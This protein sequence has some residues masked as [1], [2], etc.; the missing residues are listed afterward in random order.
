MESYQ[1]VYEELNKLNISFEIIEHPPAFTSEEADAYIEGKEGVRTKTLLLCNR[2]KTGFFLIVMDDIKRLDM[3]SLGMLIGEKGM[4]FA[5]EEKLMEKMAIRPGAVS[6]FGLL[7]N[8]AKDIRVY[9]DKDIL[10]EQTMTFHPNDNTKTL[11]LLTED[12]CRFI[13]ETGYDYTVV[14]L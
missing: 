4:Q 9:I 3:K 13:N 6:I 2:K 12:V 11:F 14:N 1:K 8:Q 5:S 10:S 7:N